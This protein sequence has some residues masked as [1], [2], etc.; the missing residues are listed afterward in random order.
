LGIVEAASFAAI[1]LP[2]GCE[3][4]M[5]ECMGEHTPARVCVFP[6]VCVCVCV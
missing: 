5:G 6:K 1:L 2:K 3:C 4:L